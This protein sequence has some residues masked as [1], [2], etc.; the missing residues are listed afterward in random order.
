MPKTPEWCTVYM[1]TSTSEVIF[2]RMTARPEW[3]NV[4]T[5][6][7]EV[8]FRR[9]TERHEWFTVYTSSSEVIFRKMTER[10]ER[11]T[12][13]DTSCG[14]VQFGLAPA[15]RLQAC[16]IRTC[17]HDNLSHLLLDPTRLSH[18]LDHCSIT[19]LDFRIFPKY[20]KNRTFAVYKNLPCKDNNTRIQILNTPIE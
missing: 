10:H 4:C 15:T 17:L 16:N 3:F 5:S 18:S 9:M 2:R 7:S 13:Y 12:E 14:Q 11:I 6:T 1:S 8:V 19:L 20:S